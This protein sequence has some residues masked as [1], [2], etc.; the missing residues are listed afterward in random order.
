MARMEYA[1]LAVAAL[2]VIIA[3]VARSRAAGLQRKLDDASLDARRRIE[4][5]AQENEEKLE[6]LRRLMARMAGG[7]KLT[8]EMILEGRLWRDASA[9]EGARMFATGGLHVI[10]VR[11]PQE[12]ASGFIAG[13]RLIPVDQIE[14][15]VRELPNDGKPMLVY[16]AGGGRSAAACE[17]LSR[18]GFENLFNLEGGFAS[19]SGPIA[20][21]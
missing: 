15:R 7:A 13:A 2:A 21:P 5:A 3:L 12:T 16:C 11:T 8:P 14:S 6:S 4:N 1:A 17:F 9:A 19:W 10:D 20:R 18:N